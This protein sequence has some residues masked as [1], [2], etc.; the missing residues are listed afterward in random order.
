MGSEDQGWLAHFIINAL[1]N[2]Q[3]TIY[4][5]GKQIRDLLYVGDLIDAYLLA[6]NN[7]D[8][9][10]GQVFNIGGGKENAVSLLTVINLIED[11]L[12]VEGIL[13][14]KIKL[15]FGK[16][17]PGDQQIYVSD[18]T[19]LKNVLGFNVKTSYSRGILNLIKWLQT[20]T[21]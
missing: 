19:K 6:V 13:D 20:Q 10:K 16:I 2:E 7:I 8:K 12:L 1:K 4:G 18:N 5:D 21:P 11:I 9:T 15:K 17:R 14:R 3:I